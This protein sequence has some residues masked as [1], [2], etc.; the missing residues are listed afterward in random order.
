MIARHV[1]NALFVIKIQKI[2]RVYWGR[3]KH[4][5]YVQRVAAA[6]LFQKIARGAQQDRAYT[7]YMTVNN[8]L[9]QPAITE[10]R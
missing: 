1:V 7:A 5:E 9:I 6:T 4:S 10:Q 8:L 2:W 3:L